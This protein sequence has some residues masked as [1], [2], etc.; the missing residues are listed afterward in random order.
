V[1]IDV[2]T[3][4]RVCTRMIDPDTA[5]DRAVITGDEALGHAALEIVSIIRSG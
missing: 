1:R 5:R 4:W 3:A 2:D